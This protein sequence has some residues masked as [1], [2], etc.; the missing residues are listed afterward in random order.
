[1]RDLDIDSAYSPTRDLAVQRIQTFSDYHEKLVGRR[2]EL[3]PQFIRAS[4][5]T[6]QWLI[7]HW[8]CDWGY[9][10]GNDPFDFPWQKWSDFVDD[11]DRNLSRS[12]LEFHEVDC[13]ELYEKKRGADE[14]INL[15]VPVLP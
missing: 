2:L 3:I 4:R 5:S 7:E 6:D 10:Y 1:L 14:L 11:P 15:L 13:L 8:D 12:L 9:A